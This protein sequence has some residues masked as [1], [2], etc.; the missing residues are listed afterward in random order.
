VDNI[1]GIGLKSNFL[2]GQNAVTLDRA[3]KDG[4]IAGSR[5]G[6]T[7]ET[8]KSWTGVTDWALDGTSGVYKTFVIDTNT[9]RAY[10]Y[11]RII[12]TKTGGADAYG[13]LSEVKIF[14][15]KENDTTRFPVSST[16]LKYPHVAMT[17]P[18]Q[19]GYVVEGSSRINY[20]DVEYEPWK[21]FGWSTPGTQ[22]P[23]DAGWVSLN[24]SYSTSSPYNANSNESLSGIDGVG[25]RNGAYLTVTFPRKLAITKFDIYSRSATT[26]ARVTEGYIYG[27]QDKTTWYEIAQISVDSTNL[28][29]YTNTTPCVI[30]TDST[31]AY[32]YA[33]IQA[34][35]VGNSA[36]YISY[37]KIELY[38]TE[39]EDVIARVGEGLDGKVANFRVYDKYLHEE[40]A[41]E[42]WDAQK[43]QFGRVES[44]VVVHK[45]RLGVGTTE[46]EG[47]FAVWTRHTPTGGVS[48]EGDD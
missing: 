47:R 19:R 18:A 5:D 11:I 13:A 32:R 10:K 2:N 39:P 43:D 46:P 17:G 25:S 16:V 12:I 45:G 35:S 26:D 4:I 27:S 9:D 29:S 30:T 48:T 24:T 28:A 3:P 21:S 42:L 23:Y 37:G 14:G 1:Q 15:H 7:W 20:T 6:S 34:T 36:G 8:M 44:S 33:A 41:L 40:Q 22:S 38:G 31:T